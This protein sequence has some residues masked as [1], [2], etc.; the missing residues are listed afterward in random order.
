MSHQ[1]LTMNLTK[2]YLAKL[3]PRKLTNQLTFTVG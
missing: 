3:E 1:R 2:L